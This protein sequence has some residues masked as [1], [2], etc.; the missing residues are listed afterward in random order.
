MGFS[1][2]EYWSILTLLQ[3][4]VQCRDHTHVCCVPWT[5][6]QVLYCCATWETHLYL[7]PYIFIS[8][9]MLVFSHQVMPNSLQPMGL[10]HARLLC[11]SPSPSL[12]KLVSTESVMPPNHLI[13]CHPLLLHQ[14]LFQWVSCSHQVA[15]VLELQ[16][17]H[18]SSK[19]YS[20]LIS[21]QID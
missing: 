1:R 20:G 6:R 2:P 17:Q 5:G 10:Q 13:L 9:Y 11:P 21:F 7:Y 4:I 19:E 18:V 15:E 3:R 16:L 12:P 8:I 14:G